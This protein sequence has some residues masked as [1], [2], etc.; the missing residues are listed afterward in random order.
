M[1]GFSNVYDDAR[2]AESYARLEFPG[3]YYLA[4]RDIPE[5][6]RRHA[7]GSRALDF[8]CGAGRSTR[9]LGQL[10]LD[11]VG[12]DISADMIAQ[13]RKRDPGGD[14]RLL[15]EGD[16]SAFEDGRFDLALSAFTFDNVPSLEMKERLFRGLARTLR[17]GGTLINL[18]SSPDIY[19]N[20]WMSF[21]TKNYPEN[22][23]AR[24]GDTVRIVMTDVE[25]ARPVEDV[26]CA[27]E[28]YRR[29]YGRA[30]LALVETHHPLAREDEPFEWVSE[31]RI[32][33]WCIYVLRA[34]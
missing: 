1:R 23:S 31:T 19:V 30:G 29:L 15:P 6:V 33:P 24:S 27:D 34:G 21:T 28:D 13:A 7:A 8:G 20:E 4:F 25:D 10:G 12:V 3:T 5:I 26:L 22:R 2:R 9:F 11:V 17:P 18:V 14:Y 16:L 32:A